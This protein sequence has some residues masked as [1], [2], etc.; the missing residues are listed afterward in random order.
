LFAPPCRSCFGEPS[1]I[2]PDI[3]CY[4]EIVRTCAVRG[5]LYARSARPPGSS[6][7]IAESAPARI[8]RFSIKRITTAPEKTPHPENPAYSKRPSGHN[9]RPDSHQRHIKYHRNEGLS[10]RK[11]PKKPFFSTFCIEKRHLTLF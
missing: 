3:D 8:F 11:P 4:R 7:R 5:R 9:F 2:P 1:C 10:S 6:H